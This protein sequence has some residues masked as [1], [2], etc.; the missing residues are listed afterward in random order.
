[1]KDYILVHMDVHLFS[2]PDLTYSRVQG[3]SIEMHVDGRWAGPID[4]PGVPTFL[5]SLLGKVY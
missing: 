2:V 4:T 3:P 1:M 5:S